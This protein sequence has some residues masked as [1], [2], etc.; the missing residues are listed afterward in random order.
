M[1]ILILTIYF[2]SLL[3]VNTIINIP[4]KLAFSEAKK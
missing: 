1:K 4:L 2:L 3:K